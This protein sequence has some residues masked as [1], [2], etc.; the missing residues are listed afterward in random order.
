LIRRS[1][2]D[3]DTRIVSKTSSFFLFL[4]VIRKQCTLCV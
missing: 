1:W 4:G 2:V 3:R